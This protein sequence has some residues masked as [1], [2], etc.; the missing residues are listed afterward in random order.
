VQLTFDFRN[1]DLVAPDNHDPADGEHHG[2]HGD[3]DGDHGRVTAGHYHVYLDEDDDEADHVTDWAESVELVLPENIA[4]GPHTIRVSLRA[5]DHHAVGVEGRIN[6][7][8]Q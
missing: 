3:A 6:I 8:V 7:E 4:P 2:D 5:L 1:F